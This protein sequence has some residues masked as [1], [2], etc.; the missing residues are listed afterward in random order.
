MPAR[1]TKTEL[2]QLVSRHLEG[3]PLVGVEVRWESRYQDENGVWK[4]FKKGMRNYPEKLDENGQPTGQYV[5]EAEAPDGQ[6]YPARATIM[7]YLPAEEVR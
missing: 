3:E 6:T 7:R 5:P 4:T 1:T 2:V